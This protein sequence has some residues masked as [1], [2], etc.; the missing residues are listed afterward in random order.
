MNIYERQPTSIKTW[1][2]KVE[3][4]SKVKVEN[5]ADLS[6]AYSPGSQSHAE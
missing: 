4:T 3:I 2:G 5:T 1:R 6:L